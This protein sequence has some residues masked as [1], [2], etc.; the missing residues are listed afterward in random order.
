MNSKLRLNHANVAGGAV[1]S[2]GQA[3]IDSYASIFSENSAFTPGHPEYETKGGAFFLSGIDAL[4]LAEGSVISGNQAAFGG[5]IAGNSEMSLIVI[6]NSGVISNTATRDGG[7]DYNRSALHLLNNSMIS[8]N[9][10]AGVGGGIWTNTGGTT[11][12]DSIISE[13]VAR[14]G[15]GGGIYNASPSILFTNCV[16]QENLANEINFAAGGGIYNESGLL[17]FTGCTLSKNQAG[18][19][20]HGHGGGIYNIA[21]TIEIVTG[22]LSYNSAIGRHHYGDSAIYNADGSLTLLDSTVITNVASGHFSGKG[23]ALLNEN[24]YVEITNSTISGNEA[25]ANGSWVGGI[26]NTASLRLLNSTVVHN[27]SYMSGGIF[28]TV[29]LKN[30]IVAYNTAAAPDSGNCHSSSVNQS[31]GFNL[32]SDGS[33]R[34]SGPGDLSTDDP[35]L[36]ELAYNGGPTLNQKPL[37][38]S[39]VIDKATI[40]GCPS[41]DQRGEPRLTDGNGDSIATCDMG[42]VE[43]EAIPVVKATIIMIK[44]TQP[45]SMQDVTFYS[46]YGKFYLDDALP[47]DGD[48]IHNSIT[49]RDVLPGVHTFSEGTLPS[50]YLAAIDCMPR[51]KATV[52]LPNRKVTLTVAAGDAITCTWVNQRRVNIQATKFNDHNGDSI[53]TPNEPYLAGWEMVLYK[54]QNSHLFGKVTDNNGS[55]VFNNRIPGTYKV[56]ETPKSGWNN[57]LPG[58]LDSVLGIPCYTLTLQ[59]GQSASVLFGNTQGAVVRPLEEIDPNSGVIVNELPDINEAEGETPVDVEPK[60]QSFLPLILIDGQ[61]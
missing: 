14:G 61:N 56:C 16:I 20:N 3:K 55:V 47:D 59:P 22:T 12:D 34:L 15:K 36:G 31:E 21:G 30:T 44:D 57:T 53:F 26:Y 18:S 2:S 24:G 25:R 54:A 29:S 7:G 46:A 32:D 48:A 4:H 50:W 41:T 33:C 6:N 39:P 43:T 9:Q 60:Q 13:N 11:I 40:N 35:L 19:G 17:K 38:G 49:Y 5:G 58:R 28:G 27:H 45:N 10:A 23:G 42:S 8:G 52:D 37:P 1:W 51:E